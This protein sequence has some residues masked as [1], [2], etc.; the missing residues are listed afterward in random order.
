MRIPSR[1]WVYSAPAFNA[2]VDLYFRHRIVS[3]LALAASPW[4]HPWHTTVRWSEES[5]AWLA[6]VKP[7]ACLSATSDGDPVVRVDRIVA[8]AETVTRLELPPRGDERNLRAYL[9]EGAPLTLRPGL[10]RPIGTDAVGTERLPGEAVPTFFASRGVLGPRIL[11]DAGGAAVLATE[12]LVTDRRQARLLRACDLVLGHDR[13]A[14]TAAVRTSDL[15]PG[16]AALEFSTGRATSY[17]GAPQLSALAKWT[18]PADVAALDLALGTGT[19]SGRDEIRLATVYLLSDPGMEEG[20][21]PVGP[22]WTPF[23]DHDV[24]WNLQYQTR[25]D[26]VEVEPTRLETPIPILAAGELGRFAKAFTD[27]INGRVAEM[28]AAL[29]RVRSRGSFLAL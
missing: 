25:F 17:D 7:G 22:G 10:F 23:V 11:R 4:R 18:S 20:S 21:D 14:T 27:D 19:D 1:I 2:L 3:A 9:S 29:A 16:S 6:S 5:G 15:S 26:A 12:G 24:F 28:E 8:P 13:P